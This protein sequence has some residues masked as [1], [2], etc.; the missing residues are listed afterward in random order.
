VAAFVDRHLPHPLQTFASLYGSW[1]AAIKHRPRTRRSR[2]RR[3]V[4]LLALDTFV[5]GALIIAASSNTERL[6]ALAAQHAGLGAPTSRTLLTLLVL[7][8]ASPFALGAIRV[9]RAL[10]AS[11]A[12][13]AMPA[14]EAALDLAQSPR[15]AFIVTLQ[16]SAL[17]AAG[18]PLVAVTQPFLPSVPGAAVLLLAI[19]LLAIPFWRSATDLHGHVKAGAQVL[20]EA[21]AAQG[22]AKDATL[23]ENA[24]ARRLVPGLGEAAT[25]RLPEDAPSVGHSLAE[26]NLRG[27]TGASVIAVER[28]GQIIYPAAHDRL[29]AGDIL[30]FTG[31]DDAVIAARQ[32]LKGLTPAPIILSEH[33]HRR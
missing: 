10:G 1:V 32:M 3:L 2:A 19:V 24:E 23:S 17:L 21:L 30:V 16:L 29:V 28:Q 5:I 27:L 14:G 9:A 12:D 31:T 33:A 7:A 8:L 26:L 22:G 13:Q 25:L 20:L 18:I 4:L 6:V 11:L 15:R